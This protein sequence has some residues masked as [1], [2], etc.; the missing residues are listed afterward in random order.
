MQYVFSNIAGP[1]GMPVLD[2]CPTDLKVL[3]SAS[4]DLATFVFTVSGIKHTVVLPEGRHPYTME[5]ANKKCQ[6]N[7]IAEGLLLC[8]KECSGR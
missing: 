6:F 1:P 5:V 3:T 7:L 2:R 8:S 4:N